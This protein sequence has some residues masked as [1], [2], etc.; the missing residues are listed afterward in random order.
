MSY[1]VVCSLSHLPFVAAEHQPSDML[2]LLSP[3]QPVDRP[4]SVDASRHLT[5]HMNDI[6]VPVDGLIQP[7][8]SHI[9]QLIDFARDWKQSAPLLIHCW[10]GISRSS[11][12]AF[13]MASALKPS[14]NEDQLAV[15][16]RRLSPSATP[17]H[18]LVAMADNALGR[19]G[20]MIRA[21]E[22]IGRGAEASIGTPFV[23]PLDAV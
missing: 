18:R 5:L 16:L 10:M 8:R 20:R 7:A 6:S 13:I 4:A 9:D 22:R 14:M 15:E 23:L 3:E 19:R 2:T 11:A 21:I 1:L 12:A 17:N